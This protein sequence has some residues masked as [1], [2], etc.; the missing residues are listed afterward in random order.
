MKAEDVYWEKDFT[1]NG[2]TVGEALDQKTLKGKPFVMYWGCIN[3]GRCAVQV[4]DFDRMS[5]SLKKKGIPVVAVQSTDVTDDAVKAHIKEHR[6]AVPYFPTNKRV[7]LKNSKPEL[8]QL[9][10]GIPRYII[11][12]GDGKVSSYYNNTSD[13]K[14]AVEKLAK[15]K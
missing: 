15:G 1:L 6:L 3:C 9:F 10:K 13:A 8:M 5:K 14:R 7:S 11:I 12:D 2:E 4:D